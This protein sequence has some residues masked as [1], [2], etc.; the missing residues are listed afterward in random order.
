MVK[1]SFKNHRPSVE[2]INPGLFKKISPTVETA[3]LM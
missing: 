3:G 2:L 1:D